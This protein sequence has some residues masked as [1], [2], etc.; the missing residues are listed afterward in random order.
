M[1]GKDASRGFLYQGFAAVLEALTQADWNQIYVEYP[2]EGDKVDIALVSN[3]IIIKS[4]QVKST[5][6]M[7]DKGSIAKWIKQLTGDAEAGEYQ[8][9][10]I[11]SCDKN[12]NIF[13][14]SIEKYKKKTMDKT[15]TESLKGFDTGILDKY[16]ISIKTLPYEETALQSIVRDSLN[17]YISYKGYVLEFACLELIAQSVLSTQMLLGTKGE[18]ESKDGFDSK[19]Y[20]W[21]DF[22]S[23]NSLKS[24]ARQAKHE[25]SFYTQETGD[26]LS[27]IDE[28]GITD[29]SACKE[30]IK[31]CESYCT[32]LINSIN[33]VTLPSY[34]KNDCKENFEI[35]MKDEIIDDRPSGKGAI[36][37]FSN[38]KNPL[39]A[40]DFF[41][42]QAEI[43]DIKKDELI[44]D[45]KSL[46]NIEVNRQ[47]FYVGNL[48]E[49]KNFQVIGQSS[50]EYIGNNIEKSKNKLIN[51]LQWRMVIVEF[52]KEFLATLNMCIVVPIVIQNKSDISDEKITVKLFIKKAD[53]KVFQGCNY[54]KNKFVEL[55]SEPFC[56]ENGI[57]KNLF[58]LKSD[59]NVGIE[60][61]KKI[62]NRLV[63]IFEQYKYTAEDFY[64]EMDKYIATNT[65][66]DSSYYILEFE[67]SNLRPRE[68]KWLNKLIFL[69]S[70]HTDIVI[71]YEVLSENTD[72]N[73]KGILKLNKKRNL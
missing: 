19:I 16:N 56:E 66:E 6:N 48:E 30:Y 70:P 60:K 57:L 27:E 8:I 32:D 15:S 38:F 50:Y 61:E 12:A 24:I 59:S 2:T 29:Y 49:K 26:F 17:K 9:C 40:A 64:R 58:E 18:S 36:S 25:L 62:L 68:S 45:I 28:C 22:V 71:N 42:N 65:Y 47:F 20:N 44:K 67:I 52:T 21:I 34:N 43:T 5:V 41:K 35:S 55:L 39:F 46:F 51:E 53:V 1:G 37:S 14:N 11:G 73:N 54:P 3:G 7:F 33:E 72:G 23:G 63:N 13:I 10:L 31:L 69:H 4:I